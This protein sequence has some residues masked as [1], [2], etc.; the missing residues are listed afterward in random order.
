M[1]FYSNFNIIVCK[2]FIIFLKLYKQGL[3][4]VITTLKYFRHE[5]EDHIY[6]KK[7]TAKS[8]KALISFDIVEDNCKGCGACKRKCPVSAISGNK[9][10]AHIIDKNIC[11]KC[12][13]CMETCKFDAIEIN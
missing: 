8:C 9:K 13:K 11:I 3:P 4:P 10:E 12:G 2:S 5:Y 1:C 7:C 6:N